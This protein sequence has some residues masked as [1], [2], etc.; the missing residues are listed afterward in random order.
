MLSR[1]IDLTANRD[2]SNNNSINIEQFL[3]M[4]PDVDA[5]LITSEEYDALAWYESIFGKRRHYNEKHIIFEYKKK[6]EA[7]WNVTCVRCGKP[8]IPWQNY[9]NVCQKCDQ[10]LERNRVPWKKYYISN[11]SRHFSD[12]FDLR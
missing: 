12:L 6:H 1:N 8:L 3:D 9:G 5:P 7:Y 4:L 10:D 2:F 11:N